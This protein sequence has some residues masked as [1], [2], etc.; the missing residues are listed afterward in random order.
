M[1][2][3]FIIYVTAAV[4]MLC[5]LSYANNLPL[6]NERYEIVINDVVLPFLGALKNGDV[7]L[8]KHY[9]A[10]DIYEINRA[11]LENNE[12]Y[13]EFLRSYYHDVEFYVEK[14]ME[15]A[16]YIEVHVVIEF[17]NGDEINAK[18]CLIKDMN[19]VSGPLEGAAWKIVEFRYK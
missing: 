12:E 8:I 11:L 17:S 4:M 2:I 5:S 6:N 10:G 3:R 9:I 16:D 15:S 7:D 14:V 18:L 13:P 19:K 1:R